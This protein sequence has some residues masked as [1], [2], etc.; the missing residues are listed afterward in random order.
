MC[1]CAIFRVHLSNLKRAVRVEMCREFV[2]VS[3]PIGISFRTDRIMENEYISWMKV[4]TAIS[5][6][7]KRS[8]CIISLSDYFERSKL[9][10]LVSLSESTYLVNWTAML[11]QLLRSAFGRFV[12]MSF[13][14]TELC[15]HV[16][17]ITIASIPVSPEPA[18]S[19]TASIASSETERLA[20]LPHQLNISTRCPHITQIS[21]TLWKVWASC[22]FCSERRTSLRVLFVVSLCN[23][24]ARCS[25]CNCLYHARC[26]DVH[27]H[28]LL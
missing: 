4:L 21:V 9:L 24:L 28:L 23:I 5:H 15:L 20:H 1:I 3:E 26:S 22:R 10:V 13:L 16:L 2:H 7:M 25:E 8:F 17:S 12:L 6:N 19:K 18:E 11:L 27:L 14:A